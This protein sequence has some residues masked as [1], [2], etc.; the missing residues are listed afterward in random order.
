TVAFSGETFATLTIDAQGV[1][2]PVS[3]VQNGATVQLPQLIRLNYPK[4]IF[5][6]QREQFAFTIQGNAGQT[7]GLQITP[8][9]SPGTPS[10]D[11]T[12]ATGSVTLTNSVADFVALYTAPTV[13]TD[14]PFDYQVTISS[15]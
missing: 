7:I 8:L 13:T 2:I 3:S 14:T 11:F 1:S 10:P 4:E 9:A 12:P 15:A 6:G 5:S